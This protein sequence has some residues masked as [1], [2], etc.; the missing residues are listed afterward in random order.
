MAKKKPKFAIGAEAFVKCQACGRQERCEV[1]ADGTIVLPK[2]PNWGW[3]ELHYGGGP[4]DLLI[5]GP[6]CVKRYEREQER[7]ENFK[8][9]LELGET[10]AKEVT[11]EVVEAEFSARDY[12]PHVDLDFGNGWKAR[13]MLWQLRPS[14]IQHPEEGHSMELMPRLGFESWQEARSRAMLRV[15]KG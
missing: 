15:S 7:Q 8:K 12:G 9:M 14:Y 13:I 3:H 4:A 6:R 5:C 1:N 2:K 10:F 11:G